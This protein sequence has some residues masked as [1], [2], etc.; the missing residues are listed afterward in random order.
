MLLALHENSNNAIF[1][2]ACDESLND[3]IDVD[4]WIVFSFLAAINC[5]EAWLLSIRGN[6]NQLTNYGSRFLQRERERERER[7]KTNILLARK[8]EK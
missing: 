7:E 8:L 1:F 4:L 5:P 6:D 3:I 2:T